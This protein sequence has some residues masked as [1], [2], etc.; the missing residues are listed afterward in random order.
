MKFCSETK[1]YELSPEWSQVQLPIMLGESSKNSSEMAG[2]FEGGGG[3]N[4]LY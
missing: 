2:G 3:V 1:F 4:F